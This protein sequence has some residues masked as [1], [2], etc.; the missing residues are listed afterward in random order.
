M[1]HGFQALVFDFDGLILETERPD[2]QSWLEVYQEHGLDLSREVWGAVIG[3]GADYFD[4]L[5]NLER[6]LG[7]PVDRE[8]V[9]ARRRARHQA[10]IDALEIL[11]G[12]A[13]YVLDAQ[14]LGLKLAVAS[15]SSRR[16][17]TGHLASLHLDS[18]ECVVCRDDVDRAKPYPDLYLA[19]TGCLRVRPEEA[20]ALEDSAN[21]IAA[22]KAAG[23]TCVA[24]PNEMTEDLDLSAADLR[25]RSLDE[26]PLDQLLDRLSRAGR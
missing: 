20:I 19:A 12:V 14:R 3:R 7:R 10:L 23:L 18:F 21:G 22:A 11:P 5:A 8:P 17:V 16:W 4:P 24:V 9:A 15:S 6:R 13:Q 26:M 25:L 2:Y 1:R